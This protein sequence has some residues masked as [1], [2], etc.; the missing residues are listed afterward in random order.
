M[1]FHFDGRN[2]YKGRYDKKGPRKKNGW[3]EVSKGKI[4]LKTIWKLL[5]LEAGL[6]ASVTLIHESVLAVMIRKWRIMGTSGAWV[7]CSGI[8]NK[9]AETQLVSAGPVPSWL[10]FLRH[11]TIAFC[12]ESFSLLLKV[13]LRCLMG[14]W[15]LVLIFPAQRTTGLLIMAP[16][17]PFL[18]SR[19]EDNFFLSL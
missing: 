12:Q 6:V 14:S 18:V 7:L 19:L 10:R 13:S 11:C 8:W 3:M 1:H 9:K 4:F 16:Q 17:I 15:F 5:F 2:W